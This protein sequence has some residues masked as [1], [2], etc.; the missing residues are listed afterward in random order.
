MGTAARFASWLA[1]TSLALLGPA[2]CG[3]EADGDGDPPHQGGPGGA[4]DD[5]GGA[6]MVPL[7][8]GGA[9]P[10][11]TG[12]EPDPPQDGSWS[13]PY[14]V[15]ALP[16]VIPGDTRGSE[17]READ[18]YTPCAPGVDEGGAEVVYRLDL[19]EAGIL[20]ATLDDVPGD[21]ADVDVH[22]LEAATPAACVARDNVG[23]SVAVEGGAPVWVV[24]DTFVGDGGEEAPGA[25]TLSLDLLPAAGCPEGTVRIAGD[26]VDVCMDRYEAPNAEGEPP[27]VMYTFDEAGAWCAARGRRLCYDD[28]WALACAGVEGRPYSYGDEYDDSVCNTDEVW[29]TYDQ[30]RLDAWPPSA[31]APSVGDLASLLHAARAT[32]AAAADSA[33]HVESLYQ[34]EPAGANPDC[35]SAFGALDLLGNAEEWTRRR[36]GGGGPDF[37]GNLKGRYWAEART[38]QSGV[39]SHGDGFR[40]YEIGFRCCMDPPP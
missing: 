23:L 33:D 13:A 25:Y 29:R 4:G 3:G 30:S 35:R 18:E 16:A 6:G 10:T 31:S 22:V 19:P 9:P 2:G 21:G 20:V 1:A 38:C 34:G 27:L 14:R 7:P 37:S 12:G 11:W 39:T 32:S 40:F 24:V 17:V 36:D 28:E 26:G 8:G 5:G 15:E